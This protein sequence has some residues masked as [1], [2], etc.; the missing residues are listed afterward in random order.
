MEEAIRQRS[1]HNQIENSYFEVKPDTL[2]PRES[3]DPFVGENPIIYE[4]EE[5][6][7]FQ[8]LRE[9]IVEILEHVWIKTGGNGADEIMVYLPGESSSSQN[10]TNR[11]M[12]VA[13]GILVPDHAPFL[14]YDARNIQ[15][16]KVI[17]QT[18]QLGGTEYKGVLVIET[19]DRQYA[20]NWE[21]AYGTRFPYLAPAALKTYFRQGAPSPHIPDFRYQ[22]L[23]EPNIQLQG[24]LR[25]FPFVTSRV[26]GRYEVVL[27]GFTSYGK[28]ISLKTYFEVKEE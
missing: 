20:A 9:T 16:V 21:S 17:R 18:Y 7:R 13:D 5:Y 8:T 14:D 19:T 1:V 27:E 12:V 10:G 3:S 28:P 11:A 6:T 2:Q 24:P 22:L 4:L 25:S 15:T 26:P 23:W